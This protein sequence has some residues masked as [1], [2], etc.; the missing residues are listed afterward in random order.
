MGSQGGRQIGVAGVCE[1]T[2]MKLI[3]LTSKVITNFK[4]KYVFSLIKPTPL[5]YFP[6]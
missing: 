1:N 5:A 2:V 4:G 3:L 6:F